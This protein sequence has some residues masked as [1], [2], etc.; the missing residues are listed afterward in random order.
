MTCASQPKWAAL[1]LAAGR[2]SRMGAQHKLLEDLHGKSVIRHVVD[3][4]RASGFSSLLMVTGYRAD[5]VRAAAAP[6]ETCY[7]PDYASGMASSLTCGLAALPENCEG[8]VI[9]LGDM[10]FIRPAHYKAILEAITAA[11]AAKALVPVVKGEWA[12]PV[13]IRRSLF[14]P[15]MMVQGDKGARAVLK[16][17]AEHVLCWPCDDQALLCDLDTPEALQQAR[18]QPLA[19]SDGSD[20]ADQNRR[21]TPSDR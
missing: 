14:A 8:A 18:Q 4:V 11:P 17:H 16:A 9:V 12:H 1:I 7:N 13:A 20:T 10:P 5:E 3:H 6:I 21:D 19:Q 15:I 2:S